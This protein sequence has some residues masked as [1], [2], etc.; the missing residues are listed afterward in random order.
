MRPRRKLGAVVLVLVAI[1]V[2]AC[3]SKAASPPRPLTIEEA[4][5]VAKGWLFEHYGVEAEPVP[6]DVD[7]GRAEV[8]GEA[9]WL[10]EVRVDVAL[11]GVR[12]ERRWRLWV[13]LVE[14]QPAV[15][16]AEEVAAGES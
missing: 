8:D 3:G 10:L 9:A 12:Q 15:V 5:F 16:R 4:G 2:S 6:V 1:L 13:T 11:E 7:A 14:G